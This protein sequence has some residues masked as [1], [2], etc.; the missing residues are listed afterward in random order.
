MKFIEAGKKEGARLVTG[1]SKFGD[2][3]H[4]ISPTVFSNVTDN[5]CIAQ[6]EVTHF[7]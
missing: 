1:G 5:M 6:E 2:K 7:F 4:F 3:G